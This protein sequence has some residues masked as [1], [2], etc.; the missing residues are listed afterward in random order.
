LADRLRQRVA[1][2]DIP[3]EVYLLDR[4]FWT[5]ELQVAWQE[6]PYI[7]PIRRTG[8]S[9]TDG[10][11]RPLF[12]LQVSQWATYTLSP[13]H[14]DPFHIN[15]A[16]VVLPETRQERRARL[17]KAKSAYEKAQQ[18]VADKAKL[19]GDNTTAES[20]R[21]LTCA[22]KAL[23]KAQARLEEERVAKGMTTLCYAINRVPNWSLKRIYSTYRGRF[24][25]ESSYRQ[26]R[27]ARIFTSSRKPWYRLLIFGLSMMLRNLWL[28]VRWLLGDPQRGRGGRKIAKGLLPF[29]MF[30]RWLVWAAWKALRFKTWLYPQTELPNPLWAVP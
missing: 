12:D 4:Q 5:Y 27:Q 24:G 21:A 13:K 22:K 14:Q 16:V 8:K 9:G 3:V 18:R 25:I 26:S 20:K 10:G 17:A 30:V 1:A 11:T 28:E 2:L 19:L 15:V 23:A 6:I 7:M 29:P